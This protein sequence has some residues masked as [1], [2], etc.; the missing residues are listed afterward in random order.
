MVAA[1]GWPHYA[2]N[3]P[4]PSTLK[5][6]ITG[7]SGGA[8]LSGTG[9]PPALDKEDEARQVSALLY[10]MGETAA[11]VLTSTNI[12]A[13]DRKKYEPVMKKFDDFFSVRRNVIL[14]RARF[15]RR[16][17][18]AGESAEAYITT[19]YSLV[20]TCEYKAE[21]VEEMLRNRLVVGMRDTALAERLQMYPELTLEK[22]KKAMRQK[23]AFKEKYQL[24]Q[25]EREPRVSPLEGVSIRWTGP[26]DWTTG[27]DYWTTDFHYIP[28]ACVLATERAKVVTRIP[29]YCRQRHVAWLPPWERHYL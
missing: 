22:A 5:V 6:L 28:F 10:C 23:K 13:E 29:V 3:R 20:E 26:L 25:G 14:E 19:L 11:D 15:N 24:L 12:S 18:M 9:A 21:T 8:V 1:V 17:Q 16:N 7:R 2:S 4:K 27:L